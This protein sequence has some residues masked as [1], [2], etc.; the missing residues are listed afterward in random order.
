VEAAST[1]T[2]GRSRTQQLS[3]C[4]QRVVVKTPVIEQNRGH[5]GWTRT[6]GCTY[7]LDLSSCEQCEY[8]SDRELDVERYVITAIT[9]ACVNTLTRVEHPKVEER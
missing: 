1:K 6:F 2:R 5:K 3:R 4:K 9:I 8:T 7:W